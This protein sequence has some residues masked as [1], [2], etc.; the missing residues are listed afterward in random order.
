M[1]EEEKEQKLSTRLEYILNNTAI[2][3]IFF[4]LFFVRPAE[5]Y[6]QRIEFLL[7]LIENGLLLEN[8]SIWEITSLLPLLIIIPLLFYRER[9]S[10]GINN[11]MIAQITKEV[12]KE[13]DKDS[14]ETLSKEEY[15][16]LFSA[17]MEDP[18]RDVQKHID[19]D[20]LF[21]KYDSNKDGKLDG[22]EISSLILE[23]F[24]PFRT[25]EP[26]QESSSIGETVKSVPSEDEMQKL[27]R[28]YNDGYL[29]KER[30]ERLKQDL[31]R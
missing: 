10:A 7:F 23:L 29:S 22:D 26:I 27:D 17:M 24:D 9:V 28:L 25:E 3:P 12:I 19:S 31:S 1:A 5:G 8:I 14:D 16:G 11:F 6:I 21:D 13:F 18:Y 20:A 30:Y 15:Q 4:L 2:I